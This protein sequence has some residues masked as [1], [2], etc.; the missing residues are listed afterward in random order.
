M[1]KN[2]YN[3]AREYFK[4]KYGERVL[5]ICIDGG[6]TCPNRD[7]TKG[8]GGCIFCGERGSGE[9][10]CSSSVKTQIENYFNSYKAGRANKFIVYFQNFSGTY[11]N[12]DKLLQIYKSALIDKRIVAINIGTRPD[13]IDAKIIDVLKEVNQLTDLTIELGLQTSN[14]DIGKIINRKY[15]NDDFTNAVRLLNEA[16]IDVV[17]HIMIG[18]PN[19]THEDVMNTIKFINSHKLLGVKL[20]S[21][22][23]IEGTV[24]AQ[25]YKT[26]LYTPISQNYY[27]EVLADAINHLNN[28]LIIFRIVADA[29]K[30]LFLAPEWN[31]HKKITLNKINGYFTTND[32]YQGKYYKK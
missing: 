6:F 21:T 18:L 5:K 32:V 9:K 7:G 27:I 29:P 15:T 31:L 23:V 11:E 13:C 19:E 30:N 24:L 1:E 25:M 17:A 3:N 2:R 22:Y 26:G 10:L 4:H 16:N 8:L 12:P 20:H 28:Q 14:E